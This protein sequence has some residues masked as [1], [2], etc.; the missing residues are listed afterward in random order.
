M[1]TGADP[2]RRPSPALRRGVAIAVLVFAGLFVAGGLWELDVQQNG[3]P[4]TAKV[5]S[6]DSSYQYR[7][8]SRTTCRGTWVIGDVTAGGG[9]E[10]G[11]VSGAAKS[12]VGK[13][14]A[15]RVRGDTAHTV[16]YRIVYVCFGIA[17]LI[18]GF[19]L[20]AVWKGEFTV[21]VRPES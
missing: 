2:E 5:S 1:A 12:D 13:E 7:A 14:I 8:G 3:T 21:S 18:L 19:G 16:T 20:W 6:C 17:A 15:V 9:V 10:F 11:V 4:A